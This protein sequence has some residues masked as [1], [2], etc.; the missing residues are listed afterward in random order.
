MCNL[1]ICTSAPGRAV[2]SSPAH[3]RLVETSRAHRR[4]V[5]RRSGRCRIWHCSAARTRVAPRPGRALGSRAAARDGDSR[6]RHSRGAA[7]LRHLQRPTYTRGARRRH[8]SDRHE[9]RSRVRA[10]PRTRGLGTARSRAGPSEIAAR[11]L[12]ERPRPRRVPPASLR[13]ARLDDEH[14]RAVGGVRAPAGVRT[15]G[16]DPLDRPRRGS[17]T[18]RTCFPRSTTRRGRAATTPATPS[19]ATTERIRRS[20]IRAGLCSF[21]RPGFATPTTSR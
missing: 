5:W 3:T 16:S 20:S 12:D 21:T 18:R 10:V 9:L 14:G 11:P 15:I 13:G 6:R 4:D 7:R 2:S 1:R 17:A 8:T 19:A